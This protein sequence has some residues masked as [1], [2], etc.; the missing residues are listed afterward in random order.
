MDNKDSFRYIQQL[1]SS[2]RP[3][4]GHE[5][6]YQHELTFLSFN[7]QKTIFY[8]NVMRIKEV[9]FN[10]LITPVSHA[11][12]WFEG[13]IKARGEIYSVVNVAKFINE[14]ASIEKGHI[15]IVLSQGNQNIA[16]LV[17]GVQ[18]VSKIKDDTVVSEKE[19]I[20]CYNASNGEMN[21][22]SIPR[23]LASP[24]FTQISIF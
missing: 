22:L 14:S 13:I 5:S 3:Q 18:G 11:L 15:V 12:P 21:V 17:N 9:L 6:E 4:S 23:L 7:I 10:P 1:A 16:F 20:D 24:K 2:E 8:I 19:F